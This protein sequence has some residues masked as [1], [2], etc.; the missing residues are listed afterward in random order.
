MKRTGLVILG[1]L[2]VSAWA[3]AATTNKAP[4]AEMMKDVMRTQMRAS[5][6]GPID[7]LYGPL[8]KDVKMPDADQATFKGLLMDKQ[9]ALM[10][11]SMDLTLNMMNGKT[12][13]QEERDAVDKKTKKATADY[14]ARIKALLGDDNYTVFQSFE[15]TKQERMQVNTFKQSLSPGDQLT[16]EQEAKLIRAMHSERTNVQ[17][18]IKSDPA[19]FTQE[20]M[21]KQ[22]KEVAQLAERYVSQAAAI[23]TPSQLEQFKN[24]T[25]QQQAM[26]EMGMKLVS[27]VFEKPSDVV[28]APTTYE[29]PN[30]EI[31][32][33]FEDGLYQEQTVGD[34]DKAIGIYEKVVADGGEI[35][36]LAAKATFQLGMCHLKKD[37]KVKAIEYFQKVISAYPDQKELVANA[38]KQLEPLAPQG[39]DGGLFSR[40]PQSVLLQIG[41][42]YG[43]NCA[44]AGRKKMYCNSHIH[45]VDARFTHFSGGYGYYMNPSNSPAGDKINLG[46][47]SDPD[48]TL[49]DVAHRKIATEMIPDEQK[50]GRYNIYLTPE[51]PVA[52]GQMFVYSWSMNKESKLTANGSLYSLKMQNHKV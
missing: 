19:Q 4:M 22:I 33:L 15:S 47:T 2:I 8:F 6:Q 18:S 7:L 3:T 26:M 36:R 46:R 24:S 37:D 32:T 45:F 23:L 14:D 39:G 48:Q 34:L 17:S 50:P 51:K 35:N 25:K 12:T 5:M 16:E 20:Q 11:I 29:A 40:L 10:D 27:K 21:E 31:M 38:K 49:Y 9:L 30:K 28:S 52:P 44:D 1:V 41:S 42:L 13:T 43:Q